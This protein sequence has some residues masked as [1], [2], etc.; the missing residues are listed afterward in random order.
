M[1]M[2]NMIRADLARKEAALL[3][4]SQVLHMS[5]ESLKTLEKNWG[6]TG[7]NIQRQ[8]G[9]GFEGRNHHLNIGTDDECF[10]VLNV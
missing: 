4:Q 1:N 2:M 6:K 9:Y 8:S 5:V 7:A 3:E 10:L